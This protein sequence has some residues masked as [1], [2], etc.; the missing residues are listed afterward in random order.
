MGD[1][2]MP[3]CPSR[4]KEGTLGM[5]RLPSLILGV[6]LWVA[7]PV[8]K[9]ADLGTEGSPA[10]VGVPG[11]VGQGFILTTSNNYLDPHTTHGS[12]QF[13]DAGINVTKSLVANL[14]G[15]VQLFA[16]DLTPSGNDNA[17]L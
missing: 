14:R 6:A 7:A 11:F 12:F 10:A 8:A 16:P 1:L 4:Y 17:T 5:T 2:A 9:A 3:A 13:S 15:G